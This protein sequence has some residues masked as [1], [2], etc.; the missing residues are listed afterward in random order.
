MCNS[1][2]MAIRDICDK[3]PER[4][5]CFCQK[6]GY[7]DQISQIC[8]LLLISPMYITIVTVCLRFL[9]GYLLETVDGELKFIATCQLKK[10]NLFSS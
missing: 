2:N 5:I 7:F 10:S 4:E 6:R 1:N 3:F 8:M 9:F